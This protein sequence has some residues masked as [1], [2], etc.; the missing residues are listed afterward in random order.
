MHTYRRIGEKK[1]WKSFDC[2][3]FSAMVF[4]FILLAAFAWLK[5]LREYIMFILYL[6]A[7]IF[8]CR[9]EIKVFAIFFLISLSPHFFSSLIHTYTTYT[10]ACIHINFLQRN[11]ERKRIRDGALNKCMYGMN[12]WMNEKIG[13][14]A[15]K[16]CDLLEISWDGFF[17]F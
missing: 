14:L 11:W 17:S 4:Q 3:Y 16:M 15:L 2:C 1:K 12:E 13:L 5:S 10:Y 7:R 8:A 6:C 9:N